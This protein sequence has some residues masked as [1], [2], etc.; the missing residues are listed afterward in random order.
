MDQSQMDTW[1]QNVILSTYN[2]RNGQNAPKAVGFTT[3]HRSA[4]V[5]S[6]AKD[7]STARCSLKPVSVDTSSIKAKVYFSFYGY[8]RDFI[9]RTV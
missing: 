6:F 4:L 5:C 1:F 2:L 7:A 8:A 3:W 9:I